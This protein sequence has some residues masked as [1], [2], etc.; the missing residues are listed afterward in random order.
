MIKNRMRINRSN[1]GDKSL[2]L[3]ISVLLGLFGLFCIFPFLH[4]IA[5]SFSAENPIVRGEVVLLP[6]NFTL[7]A[8]KRVF[9]MSSLMR[10]F[11]NTIFVASI[12]TAI[13]VFMSVC[14]AYPL[15]RKQLQFRSG[16]TLFVVFTMLFP[17]G[18]IPFYILIRNLHLIDTLWALIIPYGITTFNMIIIKNF[19]QNV[20]VELEEATLIDGA[21]DL[22]ILFMVFIPVSKAVLATVS[23]FYVVQ[24]WNVFMP[25]VY[26]INDGAKF[27]IQVTLRGMLFGDLISGMLGSALEE[28]SANRIGAEGIKAATSIVSIIPI[29]IIYPFI[30]RYFTKGIMLGSVKG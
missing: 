7:D 1:I 2:S 23:L 25:A 11:M 10:S 5:R 24:N 22:Q 4:V 14:I 16:F 29:L 13:Q 3:L 26:F 6:I 21:N 17:V 8:Y 19:F 18:I 15:S 20:P 27:P 28:S 9:Q 12:G 30:Q